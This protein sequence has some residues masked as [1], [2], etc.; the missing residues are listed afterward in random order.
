MGAHRERRT[1]LIKLH[2]FKF[3]QL[4]LLYV[5]VRKH[6]FRMADTLPELALNATGL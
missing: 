4:I 5:G 2:T 6:I 3:F 1:R